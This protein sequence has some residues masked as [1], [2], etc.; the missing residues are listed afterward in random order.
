MVR[1][2]LTNLELNQMLPQLGLIFHNTKNISFNPGYRKI[3][4]QSLRDLLGVVEGTVVLVLRSGLRGPG[5]RKSPY[6]VDF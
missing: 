2:A 1:C 6:S 4:D 3:D 5:V